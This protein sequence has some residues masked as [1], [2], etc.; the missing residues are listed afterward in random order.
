MLIDGQNFN[1]PSLECQIMTHW[2]SP[3]IF[4]DIY[5]ALTSQ[6]AAGI[7]TPSLASNVFKRS[8]SSW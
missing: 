8:L 6:A 5:L 1:K 4:R 2:Y 7:C 3:T